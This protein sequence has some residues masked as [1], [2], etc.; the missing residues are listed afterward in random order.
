M[1]PT[2]NGTGE[3]LN[4]SPHIAPL[5]TTATGHELRAFHLITHGRLEHSVGDVDKPVEAGMRVAVAWAFPRLVFL[6]E[7]TASA[8]G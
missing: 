4:Y 1:T 5:S 2:P 6:E 3:S 8:H 7:S